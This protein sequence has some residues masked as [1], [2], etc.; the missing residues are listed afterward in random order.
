MQ[1]QDSL[2]RYNQLSD[3]FP[4]DILL[5]ICVSHYEINLIEYRSTK[6]EKYVLILNAICN[7]LEHFLD[8]EFSS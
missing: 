2:D 8:I 1:Y 5:Q 3:N 7:I 6:E 4:D